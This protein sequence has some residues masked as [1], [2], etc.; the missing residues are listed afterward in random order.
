MG[1]MRT[2]MTLNSVSLCIS[3]KFTL[4]EPLGEPPALADAISS[5]DGSIINLALWTFS[6]RPYPSS[7][8]ERHHLRRSNTINTVEKM[9]HL[10]I[11]IVGE[12]KLVHKAD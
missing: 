5:D 7:T 8:Q 10:K 2:K 12:T 4:W 6:K 9:K 3:S 11:R 1:T